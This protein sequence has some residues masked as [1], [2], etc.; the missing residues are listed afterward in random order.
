VINLWARTRLGRDRHPFAAQLRHYDKAWLRGD[1]IAGVTVAAYLVPQVLAYAGVAG[2]PPEAGLWA[3][4][5][6]LAAY[7][8][9][10]TSRR[11]SVGPE[12]TPALLTAA[13]V[14][15]IAASDPKRYA[16]LAA[17]LAIMVGLVCLLAWA[18]RLGFL[19]DALSRPVLIGYLTGIAFLMV[20][21][22]LGTL[23]GVRVE[24]GSFRSE[25]ASFAS[26]A[27]DLP[28][29]LNVL[30]DRCEPVPVAHRDPLHQPVREVH[31][32]LVL[33]QPPLDLIHQPV[34]AARD[35]G[36]RVE[37][38]AGSRLW[39]APRV[40]KYPLPKVHRASR[41]FSASSS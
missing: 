12:S 21:S 27:S 31:Q 40:A 36:P 22:Q 6:A 1:L 7:A 2:V 19:A 9:I 28:E 39:A 23:T 33:D 16:A 14:G 3:A 26:R 41:P 4:V 32:A 5:A 11:L 30:R 38:G 37:V 35:V 29:G 24:S 20:S 15:P 18:A 34:V 25:I 8:V 17:A 10:G 13:A